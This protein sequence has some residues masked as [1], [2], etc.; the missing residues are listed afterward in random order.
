[1][2][3]FFPSKLGHGTESMIKGASGNV[4][5]PWTAKI[6]HFVLAISVARVFLSVSVR[7]FICFPRSALLPLA[8]ES[9][10]TQKNAGA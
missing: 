6:E 5:C 2:I 3:G 10:E 4:Q 8:D 7:F 1:M 9:W